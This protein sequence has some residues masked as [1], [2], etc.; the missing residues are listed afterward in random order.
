MLESRGSIAIPPHTPSEF[1]HGDVQLISGHI[2]VAH[3]AADTVQE[4]TLEPAAPGLDLLCRGLRR[5]SSD[6]EVALVRGALLYD[7][8]YAELAGAGSPTATTGARTQSERTR[9]TDPPP[10]LDPHSAREHEALEDDALAR[11][12]GEGGTPPLD[13]S[14]GGSASQ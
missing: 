13:E 8:L 3:T 11:W 10:L 2:F 12:E 7:A 9:F 6:D 5:I 4:V 1:D 14:T